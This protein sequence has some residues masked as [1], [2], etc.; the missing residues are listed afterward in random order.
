MVEIT[1]GGA[2]APICHGA[3]RQHQTLSDLVRKIEYVDADGDLRSG[4]K[5]EHLRAASGC[6]GLMGVVT[7]LTLEFA[8]MRYA[9]V[10]PQKIPVIRAVPPPPGLSEELLPPA[11]LK[12]WQD[13]TPAQKQSYQADFEQ[14]A[15]NDYYSEWFWFPYSDYA[16]F[17]CW[18]D[19]KDATG[20]VSF[21]DDLKIFLSF[22]QTFTMNVMQNAPILGQ[23]IHKVDLSEAA[24]TLLSRAAMFTLPEDPV[25]TYLPDALHFQRAI[26]NIRVLDVEVEMPLVAKQGSPDIVDYTNVPGGMLF[27]SRTPTV[28]SVPC[29]CRWRCA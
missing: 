8:P 10:A 15:N 18:N 14:R 19:T 26:Q 17:N 21:P 12:Y 20:V 1:A 16:W 29:G 3:G 9:K 23:L 22:L 4:E 27:S 24:V 5:V 13:L 2:N 7:H 6:F 11:L 25:T 28:R